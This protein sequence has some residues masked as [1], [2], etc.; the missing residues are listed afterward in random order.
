MTAFFAD[1]RVLAALVRGMPRAGSHAE[2]LERFYRPQARAYDRFRERLLHGRPELIRLLDLRPDA[3]V[4]E[5]CAGTGGSIALAGDA[6]ATLASVELVELCPAMLSVARERFARRGNVHCI[7]S[8][9]TTWRPA[10]PADRVILSYALTMIPEWRA[11][12]DN[13][14]AML[15]PGGLLGVADFQV[16]RA[17][18]SLERA[19]W[20]RW[21]AHSGVRLSPDHLPYLRERLETVA[22][23]ERRGRV[24][25]LCGLAAP[26]YV[27]V[28]RK[29][30]LTP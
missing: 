3:R 8:D 28:G 2:R 29:R 10:V 14:V 12:I 24:P 1:V 22:C 20:S 17:H 11:A 21:F 26:Y 5:L 19:F 13:A 7:E 4:V 16:S 27:F 23:A 25:Y 9:A 6:V 15:A 30:G 18:G